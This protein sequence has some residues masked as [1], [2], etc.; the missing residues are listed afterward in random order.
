MNIIK[1]NSCCRLYTRYPFRHEE[2][3]DK[4][5]SFAEIVRTK[6]VHVL[7]AP[8][9]G[10]GKDRNELNPSDNLFRTSSNSTLD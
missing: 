8:W 10:H 7:E 5:A 2:Y 1:T 4:W 9:N 6:S 3:I